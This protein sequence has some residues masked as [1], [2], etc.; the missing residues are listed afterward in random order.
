LSRVLV[1]G[2]GM[3]GVAAALEARAAGAE[4]TVVGAAPGATAFCGGVVWPESERD[5]GPPSGALQGLFLACP[6][7][8]R[9]TDGWGELREARLAQPAQAAGVLNPRAATRG[10]AVVGFRGAPQIQ[11]AEGVAGALRAKGLNAQAREL[12]LS[13]TTSEARRSPFEWATALDS[14][15]ELDRFARALARIARGDDLLLLPPILGINPESF[16]GLSARSSS[17]IGELVASQQSVPGLRLTRALD[18]R[19]ERAGCQVV[20]GTVASL[21]KGRAQLLSDQRATEP[22]HFD[23]AILA[24]GRYLGGGVRR[25]GVFSEPV[26]NL[27][28]AL[29][30]GKP[31]DANEPI[32]RLVGD[33]P[34]Q[35]APAFELGVSV[36]W[37]QHPVDADGRAL[38]WL[39]AAGSIIAGPE[40]GLAFALRTGSAAGRAAA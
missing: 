21:V 30:S 2:R 8:A 23:G 5:D 32:E 20:A 3:A 4:V 27:P 16:A 12:D 15:A 13:L 35:S 10:V 36:D 29:A 26:A 40:R 39:W 28:L 14:R 25:Q 18:A 22:L 7:D 37:E 17:R 24:T 33:G 9:C 31:I 34:G 11:D 6:K 1:I 38:P 19:L